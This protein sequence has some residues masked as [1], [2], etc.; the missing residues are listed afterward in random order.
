MPQ[1]ENIVV[2]EIESAYTVH[3]PKGKVFKMENRRCF[4]LSFCIS[5]QIT[6]SMNGK[7][8]VSGKQCAVLLPQGGSYTLTGNKE[9]LFPV[10]NFACNGLSCREI[11]VIPLR[12]PQSYIKQFE[13]IQ[14]LFLR[15]S[16]RLE[17]FS[18]FY[19]LLREL[20][21]ET[22]GES[23]FLTPALTHIEE[24]LSCPTLSNTELAQVLGISEVYARKLFLKQLGTTPKQYILELRIQRAKQLLCETPYTVTAISELCGFSSPYHFCRVFRQRTGMSPTQYA[25]QN[26]FCEL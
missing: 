9:G 13:I 4:G 12:N 2:T 6:Y 14:K 11:T 22:D 26:R 16:S 15:G 24:N 3:N 25:D 1:F 17:I 20:S 7:T 10:I 21:S 18:A 23:V 5:G 19:K 8:F